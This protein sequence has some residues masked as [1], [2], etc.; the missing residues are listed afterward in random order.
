MNWP[1]WHRWGKWSDPVNG[2]WDEERGSMVGY[3]AVA[4]MRVCA[5]CG[6]AEYHRLPQVHSMEKLKEE[7]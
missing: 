3:L 7:K 2:T 6:I 1:C 4:Q 5:K